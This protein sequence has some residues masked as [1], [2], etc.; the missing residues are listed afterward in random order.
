MAVSH[1]EFHDVLTVKQACRYLQISRNT[2]SKLLR[3][4]AIPHRRI[5]GIIR[6]H[7]SVLDEYVRNADNGSTRLRAAPAPRGRSAKQA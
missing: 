5:G 2:L 4:G 1:D 7:R 3:E 6:I